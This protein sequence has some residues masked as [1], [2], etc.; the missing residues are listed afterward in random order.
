MRFEVP[1]M[2]S[3]TSKERKSRAA[4]LRRNEGARAA[5]RYAARAT[6]DRGAL[7][8][9]CSLTCRRVSCCRRAS[10]CLF[11]RLSFFICRVVLVLASV[12]WLVLGHSIVLHAVVLGHGV[13]LHAVVFFRLV[14]LGLVLLRCGEAGYCDPMKHSAM[15]VMSSFF[16]SSPSRLK[17]V[18]NL[19]VH[20]RYP[21]LIPKSRESY[22]RGDN[23]SI[24]CT[25]WIVELE[26]PSFSLEAL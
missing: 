19:S 13:V 10:C 18:L 5:S 24:A 14:L 21:R 7:V 25:I 8:L 11:C 16:M 15:P 6:E 22:R 2:W 12:S 20:C 17:F 1:E 9:G 3:L 26:T 4:R 23:C